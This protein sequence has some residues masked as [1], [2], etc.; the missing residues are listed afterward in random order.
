MITATDTLFP[1]PVLL[2]IEPWLTTY[3]AYNRNMIETDIDKSFGSIYKT[4]GDY[5]KTTG[6]QDNEKDK[7]TWEL[8]NLPSIYFEE[9]DTTLLEKLVSVFKPFAP[10]TNQGEIFH[11]LWMLAI[12]YRK[13]EKLNVTKDFSSMTIDELESWDEANN[14]FKH[15]RPEMLKLLTLLKGRISQKKKVPVSLALD[16]PRVDDL[17]KESEALLPKPI[18]IECGMERVEIDNTAFWFTSLLEDYLHTYLGIETKEEAEEELNTIYTNPKGRKSPV[19]HDLVMMGTYRLLIDQAGFKSKSKA[20]E[21]TIEFIFMLGL[22]E[23]N[24]DVNNLGSKI[25]Y[26][27]KQGYQP[28]WEVKPFS[29]YK[30]SPYNLTGHLW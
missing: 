22:K 13:H 18:R 6:W 3:F 10:F 14:Y 26:L 28:K 19:I 2:E 29:E 9:S 23:E 1:V 17:P 7:L 24:D 15:I 20:R 21:L 12:L 11:A 16:S 4:L 25:A 8:N 27:E 30:T 5:K